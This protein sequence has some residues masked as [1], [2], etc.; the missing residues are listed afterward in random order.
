ML[1]WSYVNAGDC[2]LSGEVGVSDITPIAEHYCETV[3][4]DED[5]N[6]TGDPETPEGA[7]RR[8][9]KSYGRSRNA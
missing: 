2:D 9:R 3:E 5:G 6:P 4:Y 8:G 1:S 7:V